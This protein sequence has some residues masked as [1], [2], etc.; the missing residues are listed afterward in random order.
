M[1]PRAGTHSGSHGKLSRLQRTEREKKLKREK[2]TERENEQMPLNY[3]IPVFPTAASPSLP[4]PWHRRR[5][6]GRLLFLP[7]EH[8]TNA[9]TSKIGHD[10]IKAI[11][12]EIRSAPTAPMTH[13]ASVY[14]IMNHMLKTDGLVFISPSSAFLPSPHKRLFFFNYFCFRSS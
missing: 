14:R 9:G 6:L 12:G 2:W 3:A 5:L 4:F 10:L 11:A 8:S 13:N 7:E 1:S